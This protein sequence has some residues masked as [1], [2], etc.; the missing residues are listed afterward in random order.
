MSRVFS[1]LKISVLLLA[2][3]F[4]LAYPARSAWA[5][6]KKQQG[7]ETTASPV[8]A[9]GQSDN[10][11]L[12]HEKTSDQG[13]KLSGRYYALVIGIN[14]YP[15]VRRL[16]TAA[17]DAESVAEILHNTYGFETKV[18]LNEQATR[19]AILG[20]LND[21]RHLLDDQASL[22][23]Y[24]AGHGEYK[25]EVEKAY[26]IPVDGELDNYAHWISAD[27]IATYIKAIPAQHI[28]VISDS[29][30]SGRMDSREAGDKAA[31]PPEGTR[32]RKQ[33]MQKMW[34]GKS[35][36]LIASGGKEPVKDKGADNH[37]VFANALLKGLSNIETDEF[38]ARE[39]YDRYIA[40]AVAGN[41]PQTPEYSFIH[42]SGHE[43]GEFVFLRKV[44]REPTAEEEWDK[45]SS[46][47]DP[48]LFK[49]YA[50]RF[51][52]SKNAEE[53]AWR[54]IRTSQRWE[55]FKDYANKY[56]QSATADFAR[57]SADR[58]LWD[59][60]DRS[61]SLA[62]YQRYLQAWPAGA[63]A[64][65]A[66][67]Q[68]E[69][70]IWQQAQ[71]NR[72]Y[73]AYLSKY[74]RGRYAP[75]ARSLL[76]PSAPTTSPTRALSIF[77]NPPVPNARIAIIPKAAGAQ[78]LEGRID[79]D[80]AYI[81]ELPPGVYD[82]EVSAAKYKTEKKESVRVDK[83]GL[84]AIEMTPL[85]G[86]ILIGPV[87]ADATVFLNGQRQTGRRRNSDKL[88]E[89]NDVAVGRYRLRV[90]QRQGAQPPAPIERE[91]EVLGGKQVAVFTEFKLALPAVG[92]LTIATAPESDIYLDG[93]YR[94]KANSSGLVMVDNVAVGQH[95]VEVK[96]AR[97]KDFKSAA[98]DVIGGDNPRR[99][100]LHLTPKVADRSPWFDRF[101]T[102]DNWDAAKTWKL[103][104][105]G[106]NN[107]LIVGT[108]VGLE[109]R[110]DYTDF[111]LEFDVNITKGSRA[112][113]VVRAPD[114]KNYYLFML[115][116]A[117]ARVTLY[118]QI[119]KDGQL[120]R[121]RSLGDFSGALP[122]QFHV[123]IIAN[124]KEIKSY[125]YDVNGEKQLLGTFLDEDYPIG[126]IGFR[127]FADGDEFVVMDFQCRPKN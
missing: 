29:C 8:K 77:T 26:W 36:W 80:G 37:S 15:N 111:E 42:N 82:V 110:G 121:R 17:H 46:S 34:Q 86:S 48:N 28:L 63:H 127:A 101:A 32:E 1:T 72:D 84:V 59:E 21:Y 114:A 33:Y 94:G 87:E 123:V 81:A 30:F 85:T 113:W 13:T 41:N 11:I 116:K 16:K 70:T 67:Y 64:T 5:Q 97:F 104:W 7:R 68:I 45:I 106:K 18:L 69:E 126:K 95:Y 12:V 99:E 38:I 22:L 79:A 60:V 14:D 108:E 27:D 117:K 57:F 124:G 78:P 96:N 92:K 98:F 91:I 35:R 6:D 25:K 9:D 118:S 56:P 3:I 112:A 39:L 62:G 51:P 75:Y 119:S 31:L 2:L 47:P 40:Q 23:V 107:L 90:E 52:T 50:E 19:D 10:R 74:P 105:N 109:N 65:Q 120:S 76:Q 44:K 49:A 102:A 24:Y 54:G 20:A 83:S 122:T 43:K 125:L 55:D 93:S 71:Q 73:P 103:G 61:K 89:L 100:F 58:L 115:E 88:I 53:A 4:P 66:A